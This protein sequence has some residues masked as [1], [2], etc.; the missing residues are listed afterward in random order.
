MAYLDRQLSDYK[1]SLPIINKIID[2]ETNTQ[3]EQTKPPDDLKNNNYQ[4]AKN[5]ADAKADL[6]KALAQFPLTALWL[7]NKYDSN[8]TVQ[9]CKE[10]NN[11]VTD[12]GFS[13]AAIQT[14]FYAY[15]HF[16]QGDGI[17]N[18]VHISCKQR[19]IAQLQLF[20]FGFDDLIEALDVIF[21]TIKMGNLASNNVHR[22]IENHLAMLG[23]RL[24]VELSPLK[25][26]TLQNFRSATTAHYTD[27]FLCLTSG[28]MHGHLITL[29]LAEQRWLKA[30]QDLVMANNKLVSFIVNQYRGHFLDFNDL[31]QE[32]HS[33]L[34]KA[35]DR[36]DHHLGFQFSTYAGYWIRQAISRSLSRSERSVRIPCEQIAN[37]NRV[38]RIKDQLTSKTGREASIQDIAQHTQ[39]SCAEIN[40]ILAFSQTSISLD[41]S[42]DDDSERAFAPVDFLEQQTF[43]HA[44]EDIAEVELDTLIADAINLLNPREAQVVR[45]HFGL[46][47]GSEMTLQEIGDELSLTR[48][49]VRQIQVIALNKIKMNYGQQL[50]N[51]L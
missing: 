15:A 38:F 9:P 14:A 17:S 51:F 48:E 32:G 47:S 44:F 18:V 6:I 46:H 8:N 22:A 4:L 28:D 11:S 23:K 20:S 3:T 27:G 16:I 50:I 26:R 40:S 37:I 42:D 10:A 19:L 30:R 34:L 7:I 35:V 1:T 45:C 39:L 2:N 29:L 21:Y 25:T 43:S 31:V 36:F 33:G 41:G 24:K 12:S 49:R 5:M 13:V